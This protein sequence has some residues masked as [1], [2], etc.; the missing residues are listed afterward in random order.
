MTN[1]EL[2]TI[3]TVIVSGLGS[4]GAAVKWAGSRITKAIEGGHIVVERNTNA[5][6]G[7]TAATARLEA[8]VVQ[9][10]AAGKETLQAA[11]K[12]QAAVEEVEDIVTGNHE[13][14]IPIELLDDDAEELRFDRPPPA[15][16]VAKRTTPIGGYS[17]HSKRK[18][19]RS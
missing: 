15:P 11:Q 5:L 7:V 12:A 8:L 18:G 19:T 14:P 16:G 9:T 17:V 13:L 2:A 4:I 10:H 6:L 1:G 3:C